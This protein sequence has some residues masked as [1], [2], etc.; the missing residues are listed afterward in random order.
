MFSLGKTLQIRL[1]QSLNLFV[2][3]FIPYVWRKK[4]LVGMR[5]WIHKITTILFF[6]KWFP[7]KLQLPFS[8]GSC[9][10]LLRGQPT[11]SWLEGRFP[12]EQSLPSSQE[13]AC[14][15]FPNQHCQRSSPASCGPL[16][17]R[18]LKVSSSQLAKCTVGPLNIPDA[19]LGTHRM[20][21]GTETER[22]GKDIK[23]YK[24]TGNDRLT[25]RYCMLGQKIKQW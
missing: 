17:S 7:S 12:K 18:F 22:K 14:E 11:S 4:K 20:V 2:S 15:V 3:L 24:S 8:K 13:T 9:S 1:G 19:D 21:C 6:N 10:N 23:Q 5:I 25:G 16:V